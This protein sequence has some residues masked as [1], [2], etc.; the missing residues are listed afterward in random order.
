MRDHN[1]AMKAAAQ[2]PRRAAART[3]FI[4]SH[5]EVLR[6]FVSPGILDKEA[7]KPRKAGAAV[8]KLTATPEWIKQGQLRDYQL[9]GV[10]WMLQT[11]AHGVSGILGDEMGLGKTVQTITF[12][13][14]L[15]YQMGLSGPFLVVAPMS[16]LSSWMSEFR[17]WCPSLRVVRLHSQDRAERERLRKEVLNDVRTYDVVL[18]TFVPAA[19]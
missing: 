17:R 5:A 1:A 12:L 7:A 14:Y 18:T 9:E 10:S 19:A 11:H 15:K 8:P 13:S 4:L 3:A 16:V 6:P 2:D